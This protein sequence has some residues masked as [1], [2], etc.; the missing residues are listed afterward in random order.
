M[1]SPKYNREQ[2]LAGVREDVATCLALEV[3][4]VTPKANFFH[5]LAGE[6]IDMLDLAFH[7]ERRFGIRSPFQRLTGGTGWQFDESGKLS[8]ESLQWLQT[9]FP[10]IDWQARLANV[11]LQSVKDLVT[12]DLIVE[13]LYFAQ[14]DNVPRDKTATA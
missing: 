5:D 9:E 3:D 12:I 4:E 7:S 1:M 8:A 2:I 10:R 14:F 6:S 13:L 11:S